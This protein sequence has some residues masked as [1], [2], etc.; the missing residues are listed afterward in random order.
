MKFQDLLEQYGVP[1]APPDHEHSRPGW[2]NI[3]C[4]SC[5][6]V[7]H[8]R[9]GVS[10]RFPHSNCWMCGPIPIREVISEITREPWG[11]VKELLRSLE[12]DD[13]LP[14]FVRTRGKYKPPP[15]VGPLLAPHLKYLIGRG[16]N[17]EELEALWGIKGIGPYP[18]LAWRIFIPIHHH[19]SAVSWT[20]RSIQ[21]SPKLRYLTAKPEEESIPNKELLF[22]EDLAR[23]SIVITEGPFDV[24]AIGPGAVATLGVSYTRAQLIK[25]SRYPLRTVCFDSQPDAQRRARLLCDALSVFP[26]VTNNILLETGKDPGE[27]D[28]EEIKQLRRKFLHE[29]S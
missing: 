26:G 2:V 9:M 17:P 16:L 29:L 7:G 28:P 19:S 13:S 5:H 6:Q 25:M 1:Y 15:G 14:E 21:K 23:H 24:F 12:M 18:K 22:G 20:T 11:K 27:A 3:D 10:L 4:F 8:F